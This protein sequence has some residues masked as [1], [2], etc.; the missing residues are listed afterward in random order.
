MAI[1]IMLLSVGEDWTRTSRKGERWTEL[2]KISFLHIGLYHRILFCFSW[3]EMVS[4]KAHWYYCPKV[5]LTQLYYH[6]SELQI[7]GKMF[8]SFQVVCTFTIECTFYFYSTIK[9]TAIDLQYQITETKIPHTIHQN[10]TIIQHYK[11]LPFQ[12]T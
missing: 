7:R 11:N 1:L 12:S 8:S 4:Y 5:Y 9:T 2:K 10:S 6:S 3:M